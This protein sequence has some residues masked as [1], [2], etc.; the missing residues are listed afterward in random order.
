MRE[1]PDAELLPALSATPAG[2]VP[3]LHGKPV[4][5]DSLWRNAGPQLTDLGAALLE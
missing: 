2:E 5:R 1:H 4:A 3:G